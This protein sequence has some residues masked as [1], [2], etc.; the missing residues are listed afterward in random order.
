MADQDKKRDEE[1]KFSDDIWS[2]VIAKYFE[3]RGL[4]KHQLDS[5][6]HFIRNSIP[7]IIEDYTRD[8]EKV[9]VRV[10]P[11]HESGKKMEKFIVFIYLFMFVCLFTLPFFSFF[12]FFF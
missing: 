6:N 5:Y 3:E 10:T 9:E 2:K 11:V 7:S 12:L 1:Q 8:T 4:V